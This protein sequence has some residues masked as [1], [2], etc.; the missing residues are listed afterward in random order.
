MAALNKYWAPVSETTYL[1]E[2]GLPQTEA[3]I[4]FA[5]IPDEAKK[6]IWEEELKPGFH[7]TKEVRKRV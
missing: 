6:L 5:G 7:V 1:H 4:T 3:A 2:W